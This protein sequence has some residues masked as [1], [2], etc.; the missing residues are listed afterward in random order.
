[1]KREKVGGQGAKGLSLL[2]SSLLPPW[3]PTLRSLFI[4]PPFLS[5]LLPSSMFSPPS[6][7]P[8]YSSLFVNF[9]ELI[10]SMEEGGGI[11]NERGFLIPY[12]PSYH[13]FPLPSA[14]SV[15]PLLFLLTPPFSLLHPHRDHEGA[16]RDFP[17]CFLPSSYLV[18]HAL[19]T[20][21]TFLHPLPSL[22]PPFLLPPF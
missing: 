22:L 12:P 9:F 7:V 4:F 11:R 8:Q 18:L 5:L 10:R 16:R 2:P 14:S 1:M 15:P 20:S 19:P 21:P 3:P 6:L 13:S 17:F